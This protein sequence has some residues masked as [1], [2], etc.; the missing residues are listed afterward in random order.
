MSAQ[1]RWTDTATPLRARSRFR[2]AGRWRSRI[3]TP[4]GIVSVIAL[5]S[6]A[7]G[8][9]NIAAA[10]TIGG[11]N[12]QT[13]AFFGR[14]ARRRS[15]G[16]SLTLVWAPRWWLALGALG[17]AVVVATWLVSRTV[18]LPF[19]QFA[20]VV[21]PV[22]F[23]DTMATILA[24][25]TVVGAAVLVVRGSAAARAA[26]R[27]RGFALAAA[28]LIG[29]LGL[30]GVLSQANAFASAA[31]EAAARTARPRPTVG[32]AEVRPA[33]T[34]TDGQRR[35][36]RKLTRGARPFSGRSPRGRRDPRCLKVPS[37]LLS[38]ISPSVST[39]T[40]GKRQQPVY[41]GKATVR[42]V[43]PGSRSA[44]STKRP[45][46]DPR[47]TGLV[48]PECICCPLGPCTGWTGSV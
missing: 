12:A 43:W 25:V 17:N 16:V 30:A 7:A 28:V 8:A 23:P 27:V 11:D 38:A 44:C 47:W 36:T 24:A 42:T 29:A 18:A 26:A 40:K 22:R 1:P 19:G 5:T 31:V 32:T 37:V 4:R 2:R 41:P 14:W 13:H 46:S 6:I 34:A 9:I 10:A 20:H 3:G 35:S 48:G 21:L 33:A 45:S 15:S 39:S